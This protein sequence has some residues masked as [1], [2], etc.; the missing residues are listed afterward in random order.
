MLSVSVGLAVVGPLY[1]SLLTWTGAFHY[2]VTPLVLRVPAW[3]PAL[4]LIAGVLAASASRA[5]SW[6][7]RSAPAHKGAQARSSP[8]V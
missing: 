4:Y 7:R 2:T 8:E 6:N 5:I 3:L 1:E